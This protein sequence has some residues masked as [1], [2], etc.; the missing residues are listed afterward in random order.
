M[1]L[2]NWNRHWAQKSHKHIEPY[3]QGEAKMFKPGMYDENDLTYPTL[4]LPIRQG[5]E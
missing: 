3:E 5:V 4:S 2:A 1:F